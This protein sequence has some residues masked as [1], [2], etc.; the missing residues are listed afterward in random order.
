MKYEIVPISAPSLE[1][2]EEQY[3]IY[4][5]NYERYLAAVSERKAVVKDAL[6]TRDQKV[7]DSR[8]KPSVSPTDE[9]AEKAKKEQSDKARQT[10]KRAKSVRRAAKRKALA[11]AEAL[12]KIKNE[13]KELAEVEKLTEE[14]HLPKKARLPSDGKEKKDPQ[15]TVW[16]PKTVLKSNPGMEKKS[17]KERRAHLQ[18]DFTKKLEQL[19]LKTVEEQA[20]A[21][22]RAQRWNKDRRKNEGATPKIIAAESRETEDVLSLKDRIELGL[23]SAAQPT[24]EQIPNRPVLY[25]YQRVHPSDRVRAAWND[26]RQRLV[27]NVFDIDTMRPA[28]R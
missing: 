27:D 13:V 1:I 15:P 5:A 23:L 22:A 24:L 26:V 25:D 9:A 6:K 19:R 17:R 14:L 3:G 18:P 21:L 11:Q 8:K 20:A 7:R 4:L 2:S 10:A 12:K 28:P 16:K